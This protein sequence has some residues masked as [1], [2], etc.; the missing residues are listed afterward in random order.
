MKRST[1]KERAA[2]DLDILEHLYDAD[3]IAYHWGGWLTPIF[4]GGTDSSHHSG[5]LRSL[6]KRGLVER[7]RRQRMGLAPAARS[8]FL[9]R[10]TPRGCV[11]IGKPVPIFLEQASRR[12]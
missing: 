10:I 5:T 6:V 11:K 9:Y 8:S 2:R 4:C 1:P 7:K 12:S 3:R